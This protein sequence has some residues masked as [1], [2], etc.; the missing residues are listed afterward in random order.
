MLR[1]IKRH[2]PQV[3]VHGFS[4]PEIDHIA[5]LSGLSGAERT[6]TVKT[7]RTRLVAGRRG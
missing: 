2:F 1:D 6:R 5:T 3:N 7:R 4:P